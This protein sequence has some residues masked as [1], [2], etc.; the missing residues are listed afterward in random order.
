[1][2]SQKAKPPKSHPS[3]T[4]QPDRAP[5]LPPLQPRPILFWVLLTVLLLWLGILVWMRIKTITPQA[6]AP[7]PAL[8]IQLK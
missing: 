4:N 1:M 2:T 8:P 5:V 3:Q 7:G 6:G